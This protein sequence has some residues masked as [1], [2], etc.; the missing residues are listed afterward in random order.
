MAINSPLETFAQ[1]RQSA[2]ALR[3]ALDD[4]YG[5]LVCM[6]AL[7]ACGEDFRR[8]ADWLADGH[9]L[10]GVLVEFDHASLTEK[11]QTLS[12]ETAY[13]AAQCLSVLKHCAGNVNLARRKLAGLPALEE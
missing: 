6:K 3:A 12:L 1:R 4:A 13:P 5:V 7:M 8:A 11:S 2:Q 9:W 10:N